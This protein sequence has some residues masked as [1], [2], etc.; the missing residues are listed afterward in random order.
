[1]LPFGCHG[2][3]WLFLVRKRQSFVVP[4]DITG[5]DYQWLVHNLSKQRRLQGTRL[6]QKRTLDRDVDRTFHQLQIRMVNSRLSSFLSKHQY[7]SSDIK[8][9]RS[10]THQLLSVFLMLKPQIG[11][12][13]GMTSVA[14][15][16]VQES[17]MNSEIAFRLF[18]ALSEKYR[19]DDVYRPDMKDVNL[20][21]FQL[22]EALRLHL[23]RLHAHMSDRDIHPSTYAS[24]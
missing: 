1:M 5:D 13:Q 20:R 10:S 18:L 3:K 2:E 17:K 15:V 23:P 11:Y 22:D 7:S 24:W 6:E 4:T 16:L 12:C 14:A 19:L 21:Y 8:T 9:W